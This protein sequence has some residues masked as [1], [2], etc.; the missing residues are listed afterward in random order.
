MFNAAGLSP[1]RNTTYVVTVESDPSST[2]NT[3]SIHDGEGTALWSGITLDGPYETRLGAW[4]GF[5]LKSISAIVQKL[6]LVEKIKA[7]KIEENA[8][9]FS[10]NIDA[11]YELPLDSGRY[12]LTDHSELRVLLW[13]EETESN[14]Q[15]KTYSRVS[16]GPSRAPVNSVRLGQ[17]EAQ[18]MAG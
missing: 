5:P 15:E 11:Q 3:F 12:K 2:I 14:D 16:A 8:I 9:H 10:L 6:Y 17:R 4:S 1:H 7:N 13:R 18:G